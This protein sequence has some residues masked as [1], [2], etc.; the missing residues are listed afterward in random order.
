MK[1]NITNYILDSFKI[2]FKNK[3]LFGIGAINT[4]LLG[5]LALVS[6]NIMSG[7][8]NIGIFMMLLFT[9]FMT[10]VFAFIM[11]GKL[12]VIKLVYQKEYALKNNIE[13]KN[14]KFAD[15]FEG[16]KKFGAN[17]WG[18]CLL[19]LVVFMFI[20]I[21][22]SFILQMISS[23]TIFGVLEKLMFLIILIAM[24]FISLWDSILVVENIPVE[25]A[26]SRSI[27]FSKRNFFTVLGINIFISIINFK[28]TLNLNLGFLSKGYE[29]NSVIQIPIIHQYIFDVMGPISL[30]IIF[31]FLTLFDLISAMILMDLYLDRKDLQQ[32]ILK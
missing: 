8:L 26:I 22:I 1:K 6:Y 28:N 18:G 5:F 3:L 17:I 10:I 25:T 27:S 24:I 20:F 16:S 31:V 15:F 9:L 4:L 13:V 29:L 12:H 7:F 30:P 23:V 32:P 2:L 11:A 19:I 14:P 21:P